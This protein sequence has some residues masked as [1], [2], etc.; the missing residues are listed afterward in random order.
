MEDTIAFLTSDGCRGWVRT[1]SGKDAP[2]IAR[3]ERALVDAAQ[4]MV[5]GP[6]QV[7]HGR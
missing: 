2:G 1:A 5:L 7:A 6:E 4:G 3:L